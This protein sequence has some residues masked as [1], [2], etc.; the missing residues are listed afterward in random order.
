MWNDK[1]NNYSVDLGT[2]GLLLIYS[3]K[4]IYIGS[5]GDSEVIIFNKNPI[6]KEITYN[7]PIMKHNITN[8]L[9]K[10]RIL[11]NYSSIF[12]NDGYI[13]NSKLNIQLN[14]TRSLGHLYMNKY[15]IIPL[16]D[17][18]TNYLNN[19]TCI[20]LGSDGIWDSFP[21]DKLDLN[22]L[23]CIFNL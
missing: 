5:C 9:E 13:T 18:Y 12:I 23:N 15:G 19:S 6:T 17:I 1:K 7:K 16:P 21:I 3:N 22:I 4:N 10:N 20:I 8:L 14:I 2:T 11:N